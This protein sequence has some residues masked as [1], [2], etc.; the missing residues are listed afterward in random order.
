MICLWNQKGEIIYDFEMQK[1]ILQQKI[2][3]L[4]FIF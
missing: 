2:N 3:M 4:V 1:L